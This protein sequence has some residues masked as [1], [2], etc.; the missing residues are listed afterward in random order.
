MNHINLYLVHHT[1]YQGV[2]QSFVIGATISDVTDYVTDKMKVQ[3]L[4][5][6]LMETDL[7]ITERAVESGFDLTGVLNE[8]NANPKFWSKIK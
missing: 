7:H 2:T 8:D 5:V 1:V 4:K 3:V 6:E